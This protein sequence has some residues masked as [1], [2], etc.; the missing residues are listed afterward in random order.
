M[1]ISIITPTYNSGKTLART[2]ESVVAQNYQDLEYIIIDGLS[3]DN[4]KDIVA[5]YQDNIKINFI[6]EK[7]KGI[8]DAMNKGIKIATGEII[9][10]LNSDDF[11]DND[12]VLEII[13]EA[14]N[15]PKIDAVYSDIKYFDNDVN[16]TTRYWKA[17]DYSDKKFNNGWMIPHPTLF[18]RKSVYERFG[19][20][21]IDFRQAAD[22]EF[23]LRLLKIHKINLKYIPSVLVKMYAG[24]TSGSSLKQRIKG[25]GE[26]RNAWSANDLKIPRFFITR[27]ILNKLGQFIFR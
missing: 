11:Y 23:M 5:S 1:K 12:K 17:G 27:R 10:I 22:Y 25:W 19:L 8:F 14:F 21:N 7:D 15:D 3:S 2:I 6:S 26:T 24:G 20:F 18:V 13:S 16:K 9:G 4:T